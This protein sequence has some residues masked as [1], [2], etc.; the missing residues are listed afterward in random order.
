MLYL[1]FGE[2]SYQAA[3]KIRELKGSFRAKRADF[4]LEEIDGDTEEADLSKLHELFNQADLFGKPRFIILKNVIAEAPAAFKIIEKNGDFL[5]KS[6]DIFLFW[7]QDLKPKTKEYEFFE[8]HAAKIQEAKTLGLNELDLWM[9]KKAQ[10]FEIKLSKEERKTMIDEAGEGGE[11][12]LENELE[13]M[14]LGGE[15]ALGKKPGFLGDSKP[16]FKESAASPFAFIEKMFGPR[17]LLAL[18]EAEVSGQD[19]GRLIYPL[20][21]KLKQKRMAD[22]YW[23][24]ILAES[25]MRRDPKNS[26]EILE[27][28]IFSLKV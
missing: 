19:L 23:Q 13:K 5:K 20:L 27:R 22:A 14:A 1:I 21:W 11:W 28:F 6:Q 4:L 8:K 16:G 17:A 26:Y 24:G 9:Q 25:A 3:R 12:A 18:K 7:E 2:N 15:A 10:T